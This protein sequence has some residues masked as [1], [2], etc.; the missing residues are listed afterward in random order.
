MADSSDASTLQHLFRRAASSVVETGGYST[1]QK[2]RLSTAFG[3]AEAQIFSTVIERCSLNNN[4]DDGMWVFM[5]AFPPTICWHASPLCYKGMEA[6]DR[7][8]AR[9]VQ[10]LG[11]TLQR[12]AEEVKSARRRHRASIPESVRADLEARLAFLS[13]ENHPSGEVQVASSLEVSPRSGGV[14]SKRARRDLG[15]T[16]S[17]S[18]R[19]VMGTLASHV[20]GN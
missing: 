13:D 7:N 5:C 14:G 4:N 9:E 12:V 17:L 16:A 19:E 15:S 1:I 3:I 6:L 11:V 10:D 18:V 20:D 8:L 2:S